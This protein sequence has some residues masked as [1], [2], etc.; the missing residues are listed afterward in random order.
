MLPLI[1]I[2]NG[3]MVWVVVAVFVNSIPLSG[4]TTNK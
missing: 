1:F 3:I 2:I 4:D